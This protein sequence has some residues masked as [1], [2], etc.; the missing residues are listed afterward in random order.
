MKKY[1]YLAISL[2]VLLSTCVYFYMQMQVTAKIDLAAPAEAQIGE[3]VTLDASNSEAV[4]FVWK[5]IP[6][7]QDFKIID[8]G[9]RAFF[10]SR[11]A[12]VYLFVVAAAKDDTV[13]C[14]IH[15]IRVTVEDEFMLMVK[16]WLPA[17]PDPKI[18]QALARSF[19][20]STNTEDVDTLIKQTS[21]ANQAVLGNKLT[22]YKPFLIKLS[23]YLKQNYSD[24][25]LDEHITLWLKLA[26]TLKSC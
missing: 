22:Q 17:Q 15:E 20:A 11:K 23:K 9:K 16:S 3:L 10:T 7:T 19:I 6:K 8:D 21:V 13:D 14:V 4:S 24:K 12:G 1:Y 18:L 2:V 5:V 25:S 26:E